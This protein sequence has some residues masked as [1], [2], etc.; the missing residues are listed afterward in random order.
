MKKLLFVSALSM[1]IALSAMVYTIWISNEMHQQV[2]EKKNRTRDS[3]TSAASDF[4][5][6]NLSTLGEAEISAW[7]RLHAPDS[8]SA[9]EIDSLT[10][11]IWFGEFR[12]ECK[13]KYSETKDGG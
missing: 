2:E 7:E 11:I 5:I 9:R 3:V 4:S 13:A 1:I 10:D 12:E 6:G 8:L